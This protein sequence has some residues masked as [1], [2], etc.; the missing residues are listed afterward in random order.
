MSV[1]SAS[2]VALLVQPSVPSRLNAPFTVSDPPAAISSVALV[3]LLTVSAPIVSASETVTVYAGPPA[4]MVAEEPAVGG[5][6]FGV[7]GLP[8]RVQRLLFQFPLVP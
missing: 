3:R 1:S 4:E 2:A 6:T 7:F 8:W 5:P